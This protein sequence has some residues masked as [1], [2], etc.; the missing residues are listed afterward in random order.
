MKH[1]NACRIDVRGDKDLCPLCQ[2]P[3]QGEAP[4]GQ[5]Y[6][7][8][9]P[10]RANRGQALRWLIFS[11]IVILLLII[12][13]QHVMPPTRLDWPKL[14][15]LGLITMWIVFMT[16]LRKRHNI[17]KT[18][19]WELVIV[20]ILAVIWDR[21]TGGYGWALEIAIPSMIIGVV[22]ALFILSRV[23]KLEANDF[24][25]YF[26]LAA[27]FSLV[28]VI[29]LLLGMLRFKLVAWLSLIIGMV[30]MTYILL[31]RWSNLKGELEKRMHM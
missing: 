10:P 20:S 24:I 27:L 23:L 30:F 31:F 21:A 3:L 5:D 28:P 9:I 4:E 17:S 18:I 14:V 25:V 8:W 13:L 11:S 22:I 19:V 12:P 15:V 7:P 26:A 1:C 6:Y 16:V 29:F 2:L